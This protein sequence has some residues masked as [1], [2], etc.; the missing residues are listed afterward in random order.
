MAVVFS[1]SRRMMREKK[2]IEAML[3]IY[4]RGLH[5]THDGLCAECREVLD[6]AAKRL[7]KCPFQARKTTCAHCR[8]HCYKPAMREKIKSV[9]RF[10]GPRMAY[11]HPFLAI[12]HFIDGFR[13]GPVGH[14]GKKKL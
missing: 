9:M 4:C 3:N 10:A 2:T 5:K 14:A 12:S 13:K 7:A 11:R 1:H 6:Y 8:I